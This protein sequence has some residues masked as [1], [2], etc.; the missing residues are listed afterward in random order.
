ML[1]LPAPTTAAPGQLF[2]G[3]HLPIPTIPSQMQH[4][5]IPITCG[6][7]FFPTPSP[8]ARLEQTGSAS[9]Y[10]PLAARLPRLSK[11]NTARLLDR[12]CRTLQMLDGGTGPRLGSVTL[13]HGPLDNP[14]WETVS[15]GRACESTN[16]TQYSKA[17]AI[18][19]FE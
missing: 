6:V 2:N 4:V 9:R 1:E 5:N 14:P 10:R 15:F 3:F 13:L 12:S 18:R 11:Q 17:S 7:L 8:Q 16:L 19:L